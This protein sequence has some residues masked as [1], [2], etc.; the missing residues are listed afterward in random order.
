MTVT[1]STGLPAKHRRN[2]LWY[3]ITIAGA[4]VGAAVVAGAITAAIV[5]DGPQRIQPVTVSACTPADWVED[6]RCDAAVDPDGPGA[7]GVV[8][9][10]GDGIG[11]AGQ[12]CVAEPDIPYVVEVELVGLD[13]AVSYPLINP[14]PITWTS[15]CEPPYGADEPFEWV[16]PA[17]VFDGASPGDDLGRWRI[18]GSAVPVDGDNVAPYQWDS[19]K[20][21]RIIAG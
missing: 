3:L 7:P 9:A 2:L 12:V 13:N 16:L 10:A 8:M 1:T 4:A 21:F 11:V 19:V 18:V 15:P 5:D 17:E 20:T 6:Q 14:V